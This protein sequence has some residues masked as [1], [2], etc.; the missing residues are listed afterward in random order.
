MKNI[1]SDNPD[2]SQ[3][4]VSEALKRRAGAISLVMGRDFNTT[5]G[6]GPWGHG[7]S[8]DFANNHYTMDPKDL[9]NDPE[10]VV[11]G[12]CAHEGSHRKFS[13]TKYVMDLW[14]EPGFAYGFNAVEDPRANECGMHSQPGVRK[15]IQ[16]YIEK[17]LGSGGGLDYEGMEKGI[18]GKIGYVPDY[19]KW[20][21]EMIRY[22][23][24]KQFSNEIISDSDKQDFINRIPDVPVRDLAKKTIDNF[25][26]FY[27]TIP[28]TNDNL[29]ADQKALES[30]QN[31]RENIW[32]L[33]QKLV[34][35]SYQEHSLVKMLEDMMNQESQKGSGSQ[36]IS[37]PTGGSQTGTGQS[38]KSES[39]GSRGSGVPDNV[40]KEIEKNLPQPGDSGTGKESNLPDQSQ[41]GQKPDSPEG[42]QSGS[43]S[44]SEKPIKIPWDKLSEQAKQAARKAF[45][46]LPK[47][48]QEEYQKQAE[49]ELM[50]AEDEANQKLRGKMNDPRYTKTH[51]EQKE[52]DIQAEYNGDQADQ[53]QQTIEKM[54][55]NIDRAKKEIPKNPYFHYLNDSDV[56]LINRI[57]KKEL[58]KVFEPTEEEDVKYTSMGLRP[59]LKKAMQNEADPRKTDNF[60]SKGRP[61]E[62]KYRFLFLIDLS[63]S[64]LGS[65]IEETF[66]AIVPIIENLN[67]FGVEFSVMGYSSSIPGVVEIYK[68]FKTKKLT[69]KDRDR[70]GQ[71]MSDV[72]GFTPTLIA[73][74]ISY[75]LLLKRMRQTK[76]DHT[77]LI[78]LTDGAPTDCRPEDILNYNNQ[79]KKNRLVITAGYGIGS[80]SE[81][82]NQSYPVLP[83]E[84]KDAI[85]R[86]LGKN[87]THIGNDFES[88]V[89][90]GSVF[91]IIIGYMIRRPDL[92]FR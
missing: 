49:Q 12:K 77:Y 46:N 70:L 7:W 19:M 73:T 69:R 90:F 30:S 56:S 60:E 83:D 86:K 3:Q 36:S 47:A 35:K 48:K 24:D 52:A 55:E 34:E 92:F 22:W 41:T 26:R 62:K 88:A 15:W 6:I 13:N 64:M 66:K 1:E 80:G 59:A 8:W 85:A 10:D 76:I 74:E 37:Q 65:K 91:A 29:E 11:Y 61:T 38:G 71:I 33:Y 84:V 9:I 67:R 75:K 23:H 82:V 42:A 21:A 63:S 72:G 81:Y 31:F 4:V 57:L 43:E 28:M 87:S 53:T 5:V 50:D 32:P 17:D 54:N 89:E 27:Q 20:G 39:D 25:E 14:Q 44:G 58:K 16:A 78:N 51:Q 45:Q 40:K 79:I 18:Q 2:Q 68:N